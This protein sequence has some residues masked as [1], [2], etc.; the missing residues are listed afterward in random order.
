MEFL[1]LLGLLNVP[2]EETLE[3]KAFVPYPEM[4]FLDFNLTKDSSPLLHAIHNPFYWRILKKAIIYSG[5]KYTYKK[6]DIY[7]TEKWG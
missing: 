1:D 6:S 4:E 2:A 3:W 7:R 5:F